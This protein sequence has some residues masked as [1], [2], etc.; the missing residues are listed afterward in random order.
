[1]RLGDLAGNT[2]GRTF[3]IDTFENRP[4]TKTR[5]ARASVQD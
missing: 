1:M 2:V 3:E 5:E 4:K